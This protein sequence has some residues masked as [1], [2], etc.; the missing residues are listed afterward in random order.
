MGKECVYGGTRG[1]VPSTESSTFKSS[2]VG[3]SL[4]CEDQEGW[5]GPGEGGA[6]RCGRSEA[7]SLLHLCSRRRPPKRSQALAGE[8][9]KCPRPRPLA[10]RRALLSRGRLPLRCPAAVTCQGDLQQM[11]ISVK[12]AVVSGALKCENM[13]TG[14]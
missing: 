9:Q 6:S 7:S 12:P 14:L 13:P 8:P 2:G 5:C 1:Q 11:Q 3:D 10:L 4:A